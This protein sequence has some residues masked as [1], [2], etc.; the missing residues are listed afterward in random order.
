M[1][2]IPL[3]PLWLSWKLAARALG[4]FLRLLPERLLQ[5]PALEVRP[6]VFTFTLACVSAHISCRETCHLLWC[7]CCCVLP[8]SS[9]SGFC[10]DVRSLM[11]FP[12]RGGEEGGGGRGGPGTMR[13]SQGCGTGS[14]QRGAQEPS[15][16]ALHCTVGA[17]RASGSQG[18]RAGTHRRPEH[19]TS[20]ADKGLLLRSLEP[21]APLKGR[22]A[23]VA[24]DSA[25]APACTGRPPGPWPPSARQRGQAGRGAWDPGSP[26]SPNN[27]PVALAC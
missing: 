25:S 11:Y 13:E 22:G 18:W 16:K 3:S 7:Q 1:S 15:D 19:L 17:H 24:P 9:S 14:R 20:W 21:T 27:K 6:A 10:F 12:E 5:P 26:G 23:Q 4:V 2:S 8:P